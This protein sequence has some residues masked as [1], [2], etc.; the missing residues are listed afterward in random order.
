MRYRRILQFI[1][2]IFGVGD[3]EAAWMLPISSPD[4]VSGETAEHNIG[5][6][7][8]G[9]VLNISVADRLVN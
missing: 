5:T 3:A 2:K 1:S 8:D 9:A 6:S 7:N 4:S